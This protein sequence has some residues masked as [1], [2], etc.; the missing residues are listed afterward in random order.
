MPA[1]VALLYDI[2]TYFRRNDSNFVRSG[3]AHD[4]KEGLEY[5]CEGNLFAVRYGESS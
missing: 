2:V 3:Y 1:I 4:R 5:L